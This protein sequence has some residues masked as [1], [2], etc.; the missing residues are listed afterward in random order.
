MFLYM[1]VILIN[2]DYSK[3]PLR[4]ILCID[5]KSFFASVEAVRRGLDPL[6]AYIIVVSDLKVDGAVILA[7]SPKVKSEF[8]IKTGNRLFEVPKSKKLILVEPSMQLYLDINRKIH[9]IFSCF[10]SDEDILTY[11]ID[12][13]FIDVTSTMKILGNP[14]E[15]AQ[16]IKD[17]IKRELGLVV[18]IGIG[19]NPLLA[20][21]ALDNSAKSPKTQIAYWSYESIPQTVWK[22][23]KLTDF[24]GINKGY[25]ERFNRLG[26]NS[27]YALAHYPKDI[28]KEKFGILGLQHFY[29]ANGVDYTIISERIKPKSHSYSKG[30]VLPRD[31]KNKEEIIIILSEMVED[32]AGRLRKNN[33]VCEEIHLYVRFS[34][35]ENEKGFS[36]SKKIPKTSS[37]SKLKE[38]FID[39]FNSNWENQGIRQFNISCNKIKENFYE[40]LDLF[41]SAKDCKYE[42]LDCVLDDIKDK[43]G[44]TSIFKGF[45][46][47]KGSTFFERAKK[48]GGHKGET[49]V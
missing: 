38:Y 16:L 11:S 1:E 43:H 34:K 37:T 17:R 45:N 36:K 2:I 24:W 18:T 23:K 4:Y 27:V 21:L 15:I 9:G 47:L 33:V 49:E 13:A 31:Y 5:V 48:V 20:K 14:W 19:D 32:I 35:H 40:Q 8:G 30:Q 39:L 46:M 10:A 44:K 7:S 3:L 6:D 25:E 28:L 26:I 12:E 42:K 22:I 29:H 41:S